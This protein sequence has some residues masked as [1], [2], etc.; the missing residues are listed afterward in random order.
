MSQPPSVSNYLSHVLLVVKTERFKKAR[1]VGAWTYLYR[2][3]FNKVLWSKPSQGA[4]KY[5]SYTMGSKQVA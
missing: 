3:K 5:S 1:V 2:L 4:G